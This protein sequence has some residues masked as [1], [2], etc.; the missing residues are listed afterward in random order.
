[1]T[2]LHTP[3]VDLIGN[4]PLP[5]KQVVVLRSLRCLGQIV[6]TTQWCLIGGLMVEIL[7]ISRG[8]SMLRPTDDGDIIGDVVADRAVLRK[9]GRGLVDMG[10]A[11]LPAGRA[12]N[13]G[14]RFREPTSGAFID[15]LA[16]E[17]SLRLRRV[18]ATQSDKRVLE[19]PGT[20]VAIGTATEVSVI[21]AVDEPPLTIRVPSLLGAIYA[22]ATAWHVIKNP[23]DS[24]K[25]L[26]DAAALLTV[27]RLAELREAPKLIRKRLVWLHG[28]LVNANSVGW[29]YVTAQPRADAI[30]RLSTALHGSSG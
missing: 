5:A 10:F 24:Q 4:G 23:R 17:A 6:A 30:A 1:M 26:Q 11:E 2:D 22:K 18:A 15:I 13:I 14:V 7:L 12:G 8:A 19:A 27:A 3:T 16:P 29:E 28:E 20:D 9:L 21:Y 25:H